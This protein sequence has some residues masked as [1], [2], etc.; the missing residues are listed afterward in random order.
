VL[1]G[2]VAMPHL[3]FAHHSFGS[4]MRPE[5]EIAVGVIKQ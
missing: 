5:A 4:D 2:V 1:L 3:S